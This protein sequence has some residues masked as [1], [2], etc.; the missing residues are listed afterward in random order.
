MNM[1]CN[2]SAVNVCKEEMP[3]SP[4]REKS[5]LENPLHPR[6]ILAGFVLTLITGLPN[7]KIASASRVAAN[8]GIVSNGLFGLGGMIG[9]CKRMWIYL[10]PGAILQVTAL[11]YLYMSTNIDARYRSTGDELFG[12]N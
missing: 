7:L 10:L 3:I 6:I 5:Q 8:M 9:G 4:Q 2:D 11:S 12:K 1:K